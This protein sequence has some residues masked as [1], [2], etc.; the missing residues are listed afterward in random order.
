L[1]DELTPHPLAQRFLADSAQY[2]Q[3]V[4][5]RVLRADYAAHKEAIERFKRE[6][7][8]SQRLVAPHLIRGLT[9]GEL[10][11]GRPDMVIEHIPGEPLNEYLERHGRLALSNAA[12]LVL[13]AA[14]ALGYAHRAGVVHRDVAPRNMVV[15][16]DPLRLHVANFDVARVAMSALTSQEQALGTPTYM[17][18]EQI[19]ASR[20]VDERADVWGL[21][22][23]LHELLTGAIPFEATNLTGLVLS[24]LNDPPE[25]SRDLPQEV[26]GV[27]RRCL[28]KQP[29][30]RFA[31]MA[32]LSAALRAA[33]PS[34]PGAKAAAPQAY[35]APP[36]RD[37]AAFFVSP[38]NQGVPAQ[39]A[40]NPVAQRQVP[41]LPVS[42]V[43]VMPAPR[44]VASPVPHSPAPPMPVVSPVPFPAQTHGQAPVPAPA[45]AQP[46]LVGSAPVPKPIQQPGTG[47]PSSPPPPPAEVQE[48]KLQRTER[49]LPMGDDTEELQRQ[50]EAATRGDLKRT[51]MAGDVAPGFAAPAQPPAPQA[52][53]AAPAGGAAPQLTLFE[54]AMLCAEIAVAPREAKNQVLQKYNLTE[55]QRHSLMTAYR[56]R[57]A[58]NPE[59]YAQWK[60]QYESATRHWRKIYG[61]EA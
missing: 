40:P 12:E 45:L 50:L 27:I 49:T 46:A 7:E 23:M 59:E 20:D 34:A 42:P 10:E 11:D 14:E 54:F 60:Q 43:P 30:R 53:P 13:Q 24:V 3:A 52:A 33:V 25:L 9:S 56:E 48:P 36:A 6:A 2:Q 55:M 17:A 21:G 19:Q 51:A 58:A 32:Q 16:E 29:S 41:P 35:Q 8:L 47:W 5:L 18:P 22:I 38:Q 57:L 4:E 26:A 28:E 61:G 15:S 39:A 31:N 37:A 44:P 1:T